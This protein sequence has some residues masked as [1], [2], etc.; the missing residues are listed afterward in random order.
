MAACAR[1]E[2]DGMADGGYESAGDGSDVAAAGSLRI[3]ILS[4]FL[5]EPW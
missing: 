1:T 5:Q 3:A 4:I 2:E